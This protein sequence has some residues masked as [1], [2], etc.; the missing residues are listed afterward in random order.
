M[1]N[2]I[3]D[4]E[5]TNDNKEKVSNSHNLVLFFI[6]AFSISW[7]IWFIIPFISH[8][9]INIIT[10]V[11]LIGSFGP[12]LS[13]IIITSKN[14][15]SVIINQHKQLKFFFIILAFILCVDFFF[16]IFFTKYNFLSTPYIIICSILAAFIFSGIYSKKTQVA[17]HLKHLKG[18]SGKNSYIF[19]AILFFLVINLGSFLLSLLRQNEY[20]SGFSWSSF[21]INLVISFYY[22]FLFGGG[23]EEVGWRG[24][25]LPHLLQKYSYLKSALILGFFWGLWH[26]PLHIIG[27]Y[28]NSNVIIFI[29]QFS[30]A[31]AYSIIFMWYYYK[32][33]G[34]LLGCVFLHTSI[35]TF[36]SFTTILVLSEK[37]TIFRN[38]VLNLILLVIVWIIVIYLVIKNKKEKQLSNSSQIMQPQ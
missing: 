5:E 38:L 2:E 13:T 21:L 32:S 6:L 37:E 23:N 24:Y 20:P 22:V 7:I 9:D 29:A 36:A 30:Q 31:I 18:V 26:L 14:N 16:F 10:G 19:I 33:K 25:A 34:N 4:F 15:Q 3:K 8:G 1:N 11:G 27:F 35:N 17:N 28:P 12:A